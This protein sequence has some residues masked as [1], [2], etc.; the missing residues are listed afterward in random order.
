MTAHTD[1]IAR[2]REFGPCIAQDVQDALE[3]LEQQVAALTK[4]RDELEI[5][6]AFAHGEWRAVKDQ[7]AAMTTERDELLGPNPVEQ[8]IRDQLAAAQAR[9]S[10]LREALE[11]IY[12]GST[13]AK[14][15][16]SGAFGRRCAS[17]WPSGATT[18]PIVAISAAAR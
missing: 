17:H 15:I 10:K 14:A 16:A 5:S 2:L 4:E 7:L 1:L 3:S 13:P 8:M 11:L 12:N 18:T 6:N 9:E